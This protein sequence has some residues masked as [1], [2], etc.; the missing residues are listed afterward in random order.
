MKF[1]NLVV[2][3]LA[4]TVTRPRCRTLTTRLSGAI[5]LLGGVLVASLAL[6]SLGLGLPIAGAPLADQAE[7]LAQPGGRA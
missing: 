4:A 6:G 2:A 5:W 1:G 3:A 7:R